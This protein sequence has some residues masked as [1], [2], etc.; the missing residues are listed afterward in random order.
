MFCLL[1]CSKD[2][3]YSHTF[4]YLVQ[5]LHMSVKIPSKQ[6]IIVLDF[7]RY[8]VD[9]YFIVESIVLGCN[10][11]LSLHLYKSQNHMFVLCV[12][13]KSFRVFHSERML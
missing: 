1:D 5:N 13:K 9:I 8:T 11:G 2:N 10:K 7:K 4:I 6:I 3:L 12:F